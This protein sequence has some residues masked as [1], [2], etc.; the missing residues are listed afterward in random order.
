MRVRATGRNPLSLKIANATR[1]LNIVTMTAFPFLSLLRERQALRWIFIVIALVAA[2]AATAGRVVPAAFLSMPARASGAMPALLSKTGA[3]SDTAKMRP[4]PGLIPY[5]L[6]VPFWSDGATKLR[7]L[8]VPRAK[9]GFDPTGTWHFPAGTVFVKTFELA[10]DPTHPDRKRR[11]ETRLLVRDA[12]GGV[13]GVVYKWRPDNSD[14]DLIDTSVNEA[15]NVRGSDDVTRARTWYYP[16]RDDCLRCHTAGAGGVLGVSARQLNRDY[17][18]SAR[19]TQNQLR[20]WSQL[21]LFEK[22]LADA[23]IAAIPTL[24]ATEDGNRTLEDRA[25]SYLD[26]NCAQCHRPGGTVAYFDARFTTPLAQQQI[27]DANVLFDEGVDRP[28]VVAAHD[29]WRS[30]VYM[31]IDTNDDMRMPPVARTTVD[32]RGVQLIGDWIRSLPGRDVV[33]P[34]IILPNGGT[35]DGPIDVTLRVSESDAAIHYTLDGSTPGISDTTYNG[36]LHLTATTI[37]RARA[38]KPG[39]T[40]SITVQQAFAIGLP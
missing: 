7:Y 9:I 29:I 31:R 24:A 16:S 36:P 8:A 12:D 4:A 6:I 15:F 28:R 32:Q 27:V 38:Y 10:V 23:D 35:F 37:L 5:D 33:D 17:A 22:T 20:H 26:A 14:A 3:F 13:Y 21:G 11:L 39:Y 40:H 25:R 2:G 19:S 34:P 30:I 18:Y 1:Q